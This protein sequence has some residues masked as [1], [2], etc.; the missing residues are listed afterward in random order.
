M[1]YVSITIA[2]LLLT[3]ATAPVLAQQSSTTMVKNV[4]QNNFSPDTSL[5]SLAPVHFL[6]GPDATPELPQRNGFGGFGPT[7]DP[8]IQPVHFLMPHSS[9]YGPLI[10]LPAPTHVQRITAMGELRYHRPRH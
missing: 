7:Y 5:F 8:H 10:I 2:S 6:R 1:R 3:A 4:G 9:A